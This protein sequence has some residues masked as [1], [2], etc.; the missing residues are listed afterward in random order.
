MFT[1]NSHSTWALLQRD[2]CARWQPIRLICICE[3]AWILRRKWWRVWAI[4]FIMLGM[5]LT[6][7][8]FHLKH[9]WMEGERGEKRA[10]IQVSFVTP[11]EHRGQTQ[12]APGWD[13]QGWIILLAWPSAKWEVLYKS[14]CL[15]PHV[16]ISPSVRED[17]NSALIFPINWK[18][19]C[20]C[21]LQLRD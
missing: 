11:P 1:I 3:K 10:E 5:D 12:R 20:H 17:N 2:I 21:C 16:S 15:F 8:W 13:S 7:S 4:P 14:L 18:C 19:L 6:S 9:V